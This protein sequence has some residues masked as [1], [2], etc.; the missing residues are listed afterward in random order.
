MIT[1]LQQL[2]PCVQAVAQQVLGR[3][4]IKFNDLYKTVGLFPCQDQMWAHVTQP[5]YHI[6]W[7]PEWRQEQW[8]LDALTVD[9]SKLIMDIKGLWEHGIPQPVTSTKLENA[10]IGTLPKVLVCIAVHQKFGTHIW[11]PYHGARHGPQDKEG[12]GKMYEGFK[13]WFDDLPE[14]E[15]LKIIQH[16]YYNHPKGLEEFRK[17]A[18]NSQQNALES[19]TFDPSFFMVCTSTLA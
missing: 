10:S 5:S 13:Y 7:S 11:F 2:T 4:D 15:K 14:H 3:M 18:S 17:I 8:W 16:G 19:E 9:P 6:R 1:K 12:E